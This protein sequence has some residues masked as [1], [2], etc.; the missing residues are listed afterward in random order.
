MFDS[1]KYQGQR[2][3]LVKLLMEK[4][5]QDKGVLNAMGCVPRHCF[6]SQKLLAIFLNTKCFSLLL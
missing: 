1:T 5:I 2:R 4:G 6:F 3:R